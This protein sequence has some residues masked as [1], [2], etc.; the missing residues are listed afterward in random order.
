MILF[1]ISPDVERFSHV[2]HCQASLRIPTALQ[3]CPP[4]ILHYSAVAAN[5]KKWYKCKVSMSL[6]YFKTYLQNHNLLHASVKA[7]TSGNCES[8]DKWQVFCWFRHSLPHTRDIPLFGFTC[9][10]HP[11]RNDWNKNIMSS[12]NMCHAM[13]AKHIHSRW[14]NAQ[15]QQKQQKQDRDTKH[16]KLANNMELLSSHLPISGSGKNDL[17]R[18]PHLRRRFSFRFH[19]MWN[20]FHM[21]LTAKHPY[22]S[23][24][25]YSPVLHVY[26]ITVL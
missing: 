15:K 11:M 22:V 4:C 7:E 18:R 9:R 5:S 19:P 8:S 21:F 13:L 14:Q 3:P 1:Q 17:M 23:L 6:Q 20:D 10:S 26:F 24:Q 12:P 25:P 2:P 16:H